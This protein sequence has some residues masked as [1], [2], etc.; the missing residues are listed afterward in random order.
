VPWVRILAEIYFHAL[1]DVIL[2]ITTLFLAIYKC[3]VVV[4]VVVAFVI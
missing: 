2:V 1:C 3:V 4:V